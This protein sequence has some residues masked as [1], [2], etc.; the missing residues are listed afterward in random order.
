MR[1]NATGAPRNRVMKSSLDHL[2]DA[3]RLEL[4]QVLEVLFR[5]FEEAT[6][7]KTSARRQGRIL[8]VILFGSYARGNW[9]DDPVGGYKS[10][11]DL[12]V[13]VNHDDFADVTDY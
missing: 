10:D 9:V 8:K 7:G 13:V 6:K 12:L 4:A 5:E 1:I 2:P 11:Y 3:K